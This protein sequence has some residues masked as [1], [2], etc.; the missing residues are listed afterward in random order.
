MSSNFLAP[1][2]SGLERDW[3][4]VVDE[5]WNVDVGRGEARL[6]GLAALPG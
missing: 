6:G 5:E 1:T 4:L 3:G 2:A